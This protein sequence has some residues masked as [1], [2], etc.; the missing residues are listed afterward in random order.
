M[1]DTAQLIP[2]DEISKVDHPESVKET[3]PEIDSETQQRVASWS[4]QWLENFY[5]N[6]STGEET[7]SRSMDYLRFFRADLA[8]LVGEN[9]SLEK[10]LY[11]PNFRITTKIFFEQLLDFIETKKEDP[12]ERQKLQEFISRTHEYFFSFSPGL[13]ESLAFEDKLLLTAKSNRIPEVQGWFGQKMVGEIV[14]DL[15]FGGSPEYIKKI[16]QGISKKSIS[17]ILDVVSQLE[18]VGAHAAGEMYDASSALRKVIE[19]IRIVRTNNPSPIVD[20]ACGLALE[21]LR[22]ETKDPSVGFVTYHGNKE[23]GRLRK[24]TTEQMRQNHLALAGQINP[25]I[26]IEGE[27]LVPVASDAVV[28]MDHSH[29]PRFIARIDRERLPK[30]QEISIIAVRNVKE[31]FKARDRMYAEDVV[32]FFDF[33]QERIIIF[34]ERSEGRNDDVGNV[35]HRITGQLSPEDWQDFFDRVRDFNLLKEKFNEQ[36]RSGARQSYSERELWHSA[37]GGRLIFAAQPIVEDFANI[38]QAFIRYMDEL[39]KKLSLRLQPVHFASY[40]HLPN[41]PEINPFKKTSDDE[42]SLLLQHLHQPEL[43]QKIEL[44]LGIQLTEIPLRSQVH[45]LRFL[46]GQNRE[47]FDRLRGVL[48][49]NPDNA[50]KILN[51]FLG[52]AQNREFGEVLLGFVEQSNSR[53]QNELLGKALDKYLEITE[54][55]NQVRQF[56]TERYA[57]KAMDEKLVQTI[58]QNI[59]IR[60]NRLLEQAYQTAED[61]DNMEALLD[62]I[63]LEQGNAA[64]LAATIRSVVE[65]GGR[66]ESIKNLAV[67]EVVG[68][69]LEVA[70]TKTMGNI[71]AKNWVHKTTPEYWQLLHGK[72]ITSTKNPAARFRIL[73]DNDQII[74]FCRFMEQTDEQGQRYIH[75]GAFNVDPAYQS[76][77]IGEDFLAPAILL[78][79][80]RGLP[81]RCETNPSNPMLKKYLAMGFREVGR[82]EELGEPEVKLEIPVS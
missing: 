10:G 31:T 7:K 54:T 53:G 51:S 15:N 47:G 66:L 3:T 19:I 12:K 20:Y 57:G 2:E 82:T 49:K 17:E 13:E 56:L 9:Q 77:K 27:T 70:D 39:D 40:R 48:K 80:Q 81:V 23:H 42:L 68:P 16:A 79:K 73:R 62:R 1:R 14:Y 37:A 74:A 69:Q 21:R 8:R 59:I 32:R 75:F 38:A 33:I 63:S 50:N 35:W 52:Y 4:R 72:F 24:E 6:T 26:D 60:A 36:L 18:T 44:D 45:L 5:N 78:E 65:A 29:I 46:A 25:D 28:A 22:Q 41:N 55:G 61:A 11:A 58:E 67:S 34:S 76:G 30:G 43:R 64:L 71:Y